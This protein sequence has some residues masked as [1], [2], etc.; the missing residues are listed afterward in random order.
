MK[1]LSYQLCKDSEKCKTC[2]YMGYLSN[3]FQ[4][5]SRMCCDYILYKKRPRGC[6]P[7]DE[8]TEYKPREEY[9]VRPFCLFP[10]SNK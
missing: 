1:K 2:D 3:Q 6:N 10:K 5:Q 8:C 7:G 9:R 4:G